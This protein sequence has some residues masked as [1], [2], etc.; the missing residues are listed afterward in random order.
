MGTTCIASELV[1]FRLQL[2]PTVGFASLTNFL[3]HYALAHI[4][5]KT[6]M[7]QFLQQAG[8]LAGKNIT[9]EAAPYICPSTGKDTPSSTA[10]DPL[11]C[12]NGMYSGT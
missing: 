2:I 9:A 8:V 5:Q 1:P 6:D 12:L 4:Q 10:N 3:Q 7:R 11:A